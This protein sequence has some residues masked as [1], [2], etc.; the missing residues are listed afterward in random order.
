MALAGIVS[1]GLSLRLPAGPRAG[2]A[3]GL[4]PLVA[5]G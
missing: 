2:E 3:P 5:P 1:H 4:G